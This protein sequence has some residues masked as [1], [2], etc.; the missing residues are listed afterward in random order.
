MLFII[1]GLILADQLSKQY[2]QSTMSLEMSIA[3]IP[4]IFHITY[5]L[6]PGAAFGILE[7]QRW[8]FIMIAIMMLGIIVYY[9]PK[10][11]EEHP[12]VRLGTALLVGGAVGNLIDRV[13][14][15]YVVDFLDFRIWPIFNVADMGIVIGVGIIVYT[16]FFL[17][18]KKDELDGRE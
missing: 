6:N 8:F 3:V 9:Y 5:I 1:L 10:L 14:T 4:N 13:Q 17:T 16:L 18:N 11:K 2:I 12:L 7:H 15:G